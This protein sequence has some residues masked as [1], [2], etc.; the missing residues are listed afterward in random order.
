M[1]DLKAWSHGVRKANWHKKLQ[2]TFPRILIA[3]LV[4]APPCSYVTGGVS[5]QAPDRSIRAG[6]SAINH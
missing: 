2:S 5:L 3:I 4:T 6:V 1:A